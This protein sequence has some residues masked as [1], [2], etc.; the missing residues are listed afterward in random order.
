[1]LKNPFCPGHQSCGGGAGLGWAGLVSTCGVSY[2]EP[3]TA[4]QR[5]PAAV[6]SPATA[7]RHRPAPARPSSDTGVA[8]I[9]PDRFRGNIFHGYEAFKHVVWGSGSTLDH[10]LLNFYFEMF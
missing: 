3:V 6:P 1:M 9:L 10:Y 5:P 2:S 8:A 7:P 4:E